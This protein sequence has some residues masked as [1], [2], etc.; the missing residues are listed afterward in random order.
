MTHMYTYIYIYTCVYIIIDLT[1][2]QI[3][4]LHLY[5]W[6]FFQKMTF[7]NAR[8]PATP[9]LT[10]KLQEQGIC[11]LL[12][13]G[14]HIGCLQLTD[15]WPGEGK[16]VATDDTVDAS[17]IWRSPVEIGSLSYYLQGFIHPRWL[18]MGFLKNQQ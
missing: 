3:A 1:K 15:A 14:T 5:F 7:A 6:M 4:H 11:G 17:E 10:L 9:A 8:G 13:G 12:R 18:G 2:N 16:W